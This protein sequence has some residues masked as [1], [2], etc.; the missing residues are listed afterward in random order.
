MS[1]SL[2]ITN[3]SLLYQIDIGLSVIFEI[4]R[5]IVLLSLSFVNQFHANKTF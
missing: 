3:F 5:R 2:L 1:L 4:L